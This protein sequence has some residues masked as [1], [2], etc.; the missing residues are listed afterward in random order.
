MARSLTITRGWRD[1]PGLARS[2]IGGGL[3]KTVA[4]CYSSVDDRQGGFDLLV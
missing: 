4:G 2:Q 1:L 3:K